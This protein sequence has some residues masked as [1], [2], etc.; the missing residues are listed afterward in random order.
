MYSEHGALHRELDSIHGQRP[1]AACADDGCR[2]LVMDAICERDLGHWKDAAHLV[3]GACT[4]RSDTT[5]ALQCA[6]EVGRC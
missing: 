6:D 5:C 1:Q 2:T 4:S 3:P